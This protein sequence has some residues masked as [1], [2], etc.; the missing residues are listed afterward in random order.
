MPECVLC[1]STVP[2]NISTCDPCKKRFRR[3]SNIFRYRGNRAIINKSTRKPLGPK[4]RLGPTNTVWILCPVCHEA[5]EG[6]EGRKYC[7][8]KCSHT[9]I[10]DAGMGQR[11]SAH[12][13]L[14]KSD[15]LRE[16][17]NAPTPPPNPIFKKTYTDKLT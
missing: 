8:N 1:N 5:F 2:D 15:R 11:M 9:F 12:A 6:A 4:Y 14:Q 10:R 7:S 16:I 3:N 17:L 13:K